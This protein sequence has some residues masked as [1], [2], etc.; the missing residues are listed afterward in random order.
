[1]NIN[2]KYLRLQSLQVYM[3]ACASNHHAALQLLLAT[4]SIFLAHV[5]WTQYAPDLMITILR[6]Y[7]A[8]E[9]PY[10][11]QS[12]K[13]GFSQALLEVSHRW[14]QWSN[15]MLPIRNGHGALNQGRICVNKLDSRSNG[16][17]PWLSR[18]AQMLNRC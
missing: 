13:L 14:I 10:F 16:N 5:T 17:V 1:M 11:M 4:A 18:T 15:N 3:R 9:G 8:L 6:C 7:G 12:L 2:Y